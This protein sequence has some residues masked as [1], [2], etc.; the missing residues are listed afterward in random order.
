MFVCVYVCVAK[1]DFIPLQTSRVEKNRLTFRFNIEKKTS[2]NYTFVYL[3]VDRWFSLILNYDPT[4]HMF[5]SI[6]EE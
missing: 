5:Y 3:K 1:A 4:N 6:R 2:H